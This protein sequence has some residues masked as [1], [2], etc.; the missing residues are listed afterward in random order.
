MKNAEGRIACS[1][2]EDGDAVLTRDG[3]ILCGKG[4]CEKTTDGD[5]FCSTLE[6]GSARR[7][8]K[9]HVLCEGGCEPASAAMCESTPASR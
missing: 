6:Q 1:R 7:D 4:R 2:F 3:R 8:S 5:V 9:G